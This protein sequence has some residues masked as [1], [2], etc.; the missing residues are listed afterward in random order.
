MKREKGGLLEW[1]READSGGSIMDKSIENQNLIELRQEIAELKAMVTALMH[2][3][4]DRLLSVQDAADLVGVNEKTI[5][6]WHLSGLIEGKR[7]SGKPTGKL[8]FSRAALLKLETK[9]KKRGRK[10]NEVTPL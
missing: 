5:R 3:Q 2:E 6:R 4:G 8:L 7:P 9:K 1:K 10:T